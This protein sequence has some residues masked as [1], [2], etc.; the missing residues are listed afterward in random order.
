MSQFRSLNR[1]LH[2]WLGLSLGLLLALLCLTGAAL[3]F[4][5]EIDAALNPAIQAEAA[6]PAPA[7]DSPLWDEVLATARREFPDPHGEWSLEVNGESGAIPARFYP[8]QQQHGHHAE[9]SMVWFSADGTQVL[10]SQL[11]GDYLMSWI[12]E[13]HMHLLAG[14]TG[15]LVVGWGGLATLLLLITGLIAWWPRGSWSKALS[16]KRN[17]LLLR[18]LRDLHKH[19]GVW[20]FPLLIL[21]VFTGVLLALPD[22]KQQV[23]SATIGPVE[24]VP[25]PQS[26]QSSGVQIPVNQALAA[27]HAALPDA[28]LTFI[29]VPGT[30]AAPFR[31][32]VQVAADPH[33][34]FPGSFVFVDQ[35]SGRVLAVHDIA[36]GNAATGIST[37]IRP[38]HDGSIAGLGTR[39]LAIVVGLVPT[40]LFVTGIYYWL[41]RR[42]RRPHHSSSLHVTQGH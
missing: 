35:Y 30:G 12:Y 2:L 15:R 11:W 3:V 32:R 28:R 18:R 13:L 8:S 36:Q 39:I 42:A 16:F 26:A 14:E 23:F 29:D 24:V 20:S 25:E 19:G 21:L 6:G 33:R 34:R 40:F 37:W 31:I 17:A 38:I 10:R 5:L 9:R 4:Y 27:A 1:R 7:W 22:V 41:Q